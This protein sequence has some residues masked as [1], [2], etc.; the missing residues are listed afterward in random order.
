MNQMNTLSK[1]ENVALSDLEISENYYSY[2]M[3]DTFQQA[4][5]FNIEL[6]FQMRFENFHL[7]SRIIL[8]WDKNLEQELFL[9]LKRKLNLCN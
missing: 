8:H 1:S 9:F 3:I 4:T 7:K 5:L 2:D 6:K